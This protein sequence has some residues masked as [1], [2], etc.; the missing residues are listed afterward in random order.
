MPGYPAV[1]EGGDDGHLPKLVVRDAALAVLAGHIG[2]GK[3]KVGALARMERA[4]VLLFE[5]RVSRCGSEAVQSLSAREALR[6]EPGVV[7]GQGEAEGKAEKCERRVQRMWMGAGLCNGHTW[8]L[9]SPVG[10]A[11]NHR[12]R[13]AV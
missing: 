3:D 10:H 13:R 12:A 6:R 1:D 4:A 5:L 7:T 8:R 2:T 9:T 11:V